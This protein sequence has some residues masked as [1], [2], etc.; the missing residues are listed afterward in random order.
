MGFSA[1]FAET[2]SKAL[3]I[4][5]IPFL[6]FFFGFYD[7]AWTPMNY[8]Y[9]TEIMP[10]H[11]RTK[12]LAGYNTI[13][14]LGNSFNQFV[15]PIALQALTWKYYAVYICLDCIYVV[16]IYF[17]FPETKKLSIEEVSLVFDYGMKDGRAKAAAKFSTKGIDGD[18]QPTKAPSA[19]HREYCE[20]V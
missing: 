8:S 20:K 7:I 1:G 5:A 4:C 3:G 19:E 2:G 13:S 15:N 18:D 16:L 10:F 6:F 12:A 14:Q 9:V 17:F 11:L